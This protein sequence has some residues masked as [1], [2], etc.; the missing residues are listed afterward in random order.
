MKTMKRKH[1]I[2]TAI[3]GV[4]ILL[5]VV[6]GIFIK[7]YPFGMSCD[8]TA[9]D[10]KAERLWQENTEVVDSIQKEYPDSTGVSV[11][12]DTSTCAG[13]AFLHVDYNTA[14]TRSNIDKILRSSTLR[15]IPVE[16]QNI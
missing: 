10:A 15:E 6:V 7:G 9:D 8:K 14:E 16:W 2:W 3:C 1:F 5:V 13:G 4:I 11:R 12:L